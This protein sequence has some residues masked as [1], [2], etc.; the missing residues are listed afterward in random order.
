MTGTGVVAV[1]WFGLCRSILLSRL[2]RR[3]PFNA[4]ALEGNG[5]S[6]LYPRRVRRS[7]GGRVLSYAHALYRPPEDGFK[8]RAHAIH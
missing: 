2:I 7:T 8:W 6:Q 4:A 1:N 3:E 5:T